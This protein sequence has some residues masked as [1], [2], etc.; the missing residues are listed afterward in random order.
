MGNYVKRKKDMNFASLDSLQ[1][2]ANVVNDASLAL[3]DKTRTIKDTPLSEVVAGALGAGVGGAISF[4]ALYAAGTVGLSAAGIT[5]ALAAA[6]AVVGGGM[7][8]GIFVLAAPVAALAGLGVGLVSR[9]KNQQLKQEKERLYKAALEKQQAI[10]KA[11][12]TET[13]ASKER[14]DYLEGLNI[15]LKKAIEDLRKDLGYSA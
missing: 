14:M 7:A 11:I 12:R 8:A 15:L 5:S 13:E 1:S 3:N 4:A 2:V 6:G 10:I 9:K